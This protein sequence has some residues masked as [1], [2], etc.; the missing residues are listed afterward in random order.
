[1]LG[2]LTVLSIAT[3]STVIASA[4]FGGDSK[5]TVEY[6]KFENNEL[7]EIKNISNNYNHK[8][9]ESKELSNLLVNTPLE[10]NLISR[11]KNAY[12][13]IDK[14]SFENAISSEYDSDV[15]RDDEGYITMTTIVYDY[16]KCVTGEEIFYTKVYVDYNKNFKMRNQDVLAIRTG[17]G[18]VQYFDEPLSYGFTYNR[19]LNGDKL[20]S[21]DVSVDY[22]SSYGI[23]YK[24]NLPSDDGLGVSGGNPINNSHLYCDYYFIAKSTT[25][26]QTAYIHNEKWFGG[27]LT[28]SLGAVGINI[29]GGNTTYYGKGINV[30]I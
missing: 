2:L 12:I 11:S 29:K 25:F 18:S 20:Y 19:L 28:V 16:G 23:M 14:L 21:S 30:Y 10:E 1:M 26:V 24:F 8:S 17:D 3:L 22:S 9:R 13:S 7:Y 15:Y 4:E 5:L 6:L 27:N